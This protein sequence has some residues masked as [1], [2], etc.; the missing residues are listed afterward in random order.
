MPD[1]DPSPSTRRRAHP[2]ECVL[3]VNDRPERVEG[4]GQFYNAD[5]QHVVAVT[6]VTPARDCVRVSF[7]PQTGEPS[8][9]RYREDDEAGQR[10]QR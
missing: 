1:P 9:W 6:F 2:P 10:V 3:W 5:A 8:I 7:D 4:L